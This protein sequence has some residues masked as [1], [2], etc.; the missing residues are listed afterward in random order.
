MCFV[1][2][3]G[4]VDP[5][6]AVSSEEK[7]DVTGIAGDT[8]QMMFISDPKMFS[9]RRQALSARGQWGEGSSYPEHVLFVGERRSLI[10]GF[11]NL[12]SDRPSTMATNTWRQIAVDDQL[13]RRELSHRWTARTNH[14]EV[15]EDRCG[16]WSEQSTRINRHFIGLSF[17]GCRWL[18]LWRSSTSQSHTTRIRRGRRCLS[19]PSILLRLIPMAVRTL[20][21]SRN[22]SW[23]AIDEECIQKLSFWADINR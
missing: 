2:L 20:L 5:N 19:P 18:L 8:D 23:L 3:K 1:F 9:Q 12:N 16:C 4:T 21:V 10:L 15:A 14:R 6:P 7:P 17:D 13:E 11:Y 22:G